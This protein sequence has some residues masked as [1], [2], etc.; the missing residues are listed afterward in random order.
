ML[1][2]DALQANSHSQNKRNRRFGELQS[3][4]A[5]SS[6]GISSSRLRRM[7]KTS[8]KCGWLQ[9]IRAGLAIRHSS[10]LDFMFEHFGSILYLNHQ[11]GLKQQTRTRWL[12]PPKPQAPPALYVAPHTTCTAA[13]FPLKWHAKA[14]VTKVKFHLASKTVQRVQQLTASRISSSLPLL[15]SAAA[16]TATAAA[17]EVQATP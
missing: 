7:C 4:R 12:G 9:R 16:E 6:N 13:S 5:R 8:D 2:A 15:A 14:L 3:H 17:G 1:Q 11:A 10:I